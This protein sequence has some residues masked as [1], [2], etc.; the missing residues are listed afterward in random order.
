ME[1]KQ[2]VHVKKLAFKELIDDKNEL[3]RTSLKAEASR[4]WWWL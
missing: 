2:R 4:R 1:L 3:S